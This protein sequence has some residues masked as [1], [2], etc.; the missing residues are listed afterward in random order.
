MDQK[1]VISSLPGLQPGEIGRACQKLANRAQGHGWGFAQAEDYVQDYLLAHLENGAGIVEFAKTQNFYLTHRLSPDGRVHRTCGD[2]RA[3]QGYAG[4]YED[5]VE[6]LESHSTDYP[7]GL[8]TA[9]QKRCFEFLANLDEEYVM[10]RVGCG[11]ARAKQII[12]RA[13]DIIVRVA[14]NPDDYDGFFENLE[15]E[16]FDRWFNVTFV[17]KGQ[18]GGRKKKGQD[19][20]PSGQK[21]LFDD[22]GDE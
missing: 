10:A 3:T 5:A 7:V 14:A 17:G 4:D 16:D 15:I 20:Y 2:L 21:D 9:Y 22:E 19:D 13:T 1:S 6:T 18:G 8:M 12:D 11:E